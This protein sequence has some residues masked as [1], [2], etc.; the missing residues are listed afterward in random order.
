MLCRKIASQRNHRRVGGHPPD[1]RT[2]D[3]FVVQQCHR[4]IGAITQHSAGRIVD[5]NKTRQWSTTKR[6]QRSGEAGCLKHVG[7]RR[8]IVGGA[9]HV[10][11][12]GEPARNGVLAGV[13][14][15]VVIPTGRRNAGAVTA[16]RGKAAMGPRHPGDGHFG[17]GHAAQLSGIDPSLLGMLGALERRHMPCTA[18]HRNAH[19]TV[20]E[21]GANA[22]AHLRLA[23]TFDALGGHKIGVIGLTKHAHCLGDGLEDRAALTMLD[24]VFPPPLGIV[25]ASGERQFG[26]WIGRALIE[27]FE[28]GLHLGWP[29]RQHVGKREVDEPHRHIGIGGPAQRHPL[30]AKRCVGVKQRSVGLANGVPEHGDRRMHI[31]V[32]SQRCDGVGFAWTL[33]EHHVWRV[34]AQRAFDGQRRPRPV[35]THAV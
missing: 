32:G 33:D 10:C 22:G 27:G 2:H 7:S 5:L 29:R 35:V 4:R 3:E 31:G 25:V 1:E 6:R 14:E 19:I 11:R 17:F 18:H 28:R 26:K 13:G 20:G 12:L 21:R 24:D 23:A 16:S 9:Q 30:G 15:Q 8:A 34:I